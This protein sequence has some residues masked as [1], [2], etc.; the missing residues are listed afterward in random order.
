MACFTT[1]S[2]SLESNN[3]YELKCVWKEAIMA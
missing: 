1:F 2:I 3:E